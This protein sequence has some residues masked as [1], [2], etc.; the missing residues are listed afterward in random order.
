MCGVLR[1]LWE[2]SVQDFKDFEE[3]VEAIKENI[4][5]LGKLIDF[6]ELEY[7][8]IQELMDSQGDELTNGEFMEIEQERAVE[9]DESEESARI[10]TTTGMAEAFQHLESFI[11]YFRDNDPN[12]D[13]RSQVTIGVEN[14]AN[15]YKLPYNKN[16]S[17]KVQLS[18]HN[19][20]QR[21]G[22]AW[23]P[24]ETDLIFKLNK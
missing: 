1:Q 11:S 24:S 2:D 17:A 21:K 13:R 5:Q 12:M 16:K 6:D 8:D 3:P 23:H 15:C 19:F 7:E 14:A 20:F 9:E 10:L 22:V 4:V 18:L